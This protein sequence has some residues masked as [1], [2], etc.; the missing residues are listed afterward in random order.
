MIGPRSERW[1]L[2]RRVVGADLILIVEALES[3]VKASR[4]ALTLAKD[5]S[6]CR[7]EGSRSESG[8]RC[9][10]RKRS[11]QTALFDWL[12]TYS[13]VGLTDCSTSHPFLFQ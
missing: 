12:L 4:A 3:P 9:L 11:P 7:G 10:L 8:F 6:A 2:Q 13:T 5:V 1:L